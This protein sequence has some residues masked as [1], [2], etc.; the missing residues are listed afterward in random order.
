MSDHADAVET[1]LAATH[2]S[3]RPKEVESGA[4]DEQ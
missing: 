4:Q 3:G 1:S 2:L